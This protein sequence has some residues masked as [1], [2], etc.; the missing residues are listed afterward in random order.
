[1]AVRQIIEGQKEMREDISELKKQLLNPYDGVIVE[2]QKN[3][4]HRK[5]VVS[6]EAERLVMMEEHRNLVKWKN[7]FQKI[8]I[9]VLSSVG[10]IGAWL[11]S[12][13]VLKK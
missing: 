5:E 10:A 11:L 13:F 7:N 12:E 6:L 9:A 8:S 2:T 3:S 1:M 4:E